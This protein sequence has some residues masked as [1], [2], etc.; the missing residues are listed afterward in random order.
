MCFRKYD[1]LRAKSRELWSFVDG[2]SV[3]K[4]AIDLRQNGGGDF[5][6]GRKYLVEEVVRRP[7]LRAYVITGSRTFSAAMKNSIDFRE[8]AHATLVGETIGEKPNSYSE[9]DELTLPN[10]R[11]DVSYSTKYYR[12]LPD[13]RLVVPDEEI[14]PTWADW[15]ASRD[16]VLDWIVR[17]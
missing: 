8:I 4:I 3:Q 2:H 6:V 14:K 12:F 16:P 1:D 13:D 17:Q 7:K 10:S 11:I 15:V 5:N 9:N